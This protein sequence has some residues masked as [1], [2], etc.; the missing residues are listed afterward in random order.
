M[1]QQPWTFLVVRDRAK[2]ERMRKRTLE[3][4]VKYF[5]SQKDLKPAELET[6]K[7]QAFA[8]RR[9]ISPLRSMSPCWWIPSVHAADMRPST[10]APWRRPTSCSRRAPWATGPRT[11]RMASQMR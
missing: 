3:N 9:D 10:T 1:N 5:D 11:L 8:S 7:V 4:I 6:K 2:I